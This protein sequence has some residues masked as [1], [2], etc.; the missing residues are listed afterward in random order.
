M[1]AQENSWSGPLQNGLFAV[2][3]GVAASGVHVWAGWSDEHRIVFHVVGHTSL[4]V[5]AAWI[6]TLLVSIVYLVVSRGKAV[7]A[8][9]GLAMAAVGLFALLSA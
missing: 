4:V 7:L 8:F 5:A 1:P 9:I 2:L 6:L 3:T